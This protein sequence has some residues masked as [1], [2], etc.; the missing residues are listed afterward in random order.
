MKMSENNDHNSANSLSIAGGLILPRLKVLSIE[1]IY[2]N[3]GTDFPPIIEGLAEATFKG[4]PFSEPILVPHEH[5]AMGMAYGNY[6]VS[7]SP[8]AVILHTNVGLANATTGIINAACENVPIIVMSGRTP[9]TETGRFGSR[10][11]PI[12]WG[13]E[14][15]DQAS[16][17]REACKWEYE[18]RFPEQLMELLDRAYA[19]ANSTP[20][21]PVYLSLPREVISMKVDNQKLFSKLGFATFEST[22]DVDKIELL[23]DWLE[24]SSFPLLIT[25]R[26][27]DDES[28]FGKLNALIEKYGMATCTWWAT[29]LT[30]S[31]EN[32]CHIGSNP[33]PYLEN[34]DLILVL[35][36][37]APWQPSIHKISN[38]AKI[39]NLGPDPLFSRFPIRNFGS[40]LTI[41]GDV[42]AIITE[43]STQLE[44]R[45]KIPA[46]KVQKRKNTFNGQ[47]KKKSD[48]AKA[49]ENSI[50]FGVITKQAVSS[51]LGQILQDL[52]STV[53]SEL[54]AD[55]DLLGR[56]SHGS[57][58][59]EP[60]S[61]GLGW[62]FP[63]ALGAKIANPEKLIIAIMGDGSYLFAN[64]T[65]CHQVTEALRLPILVVVLNNRE[66]GAVKHSVLNMFP[67][68]FASRMNNV[69]LT[70]LEP[71]PDFCKVA[72]A[73]NAWSQRVDV[74]SEL[75]DVL[76]KGIEV[77]MNEQR[78]ALI[79]VLVESTQ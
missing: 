33:Q 2:V 52:D 22:P 28:S 70:S 29:G 73:S 14:M 58:F 78:A 59:Q 37:P 74:F 39:V 71:S 11:V 79:E 21:G 41:S 6:K 10:T 1:H 46:D 17:I 61:G 24:Q 36:S 47:D 49:I 43:L 72:A 51:V 4:I 75:K 60:Y 19:M 13:Q 8:Q 34:A 45:N 53:F 48:R 7:R 32:P 30:V 23:C 44:K 63:S 76:L 5:V 38:K 50:K 54:G 18:V 40:D 67:D 56:T 77:T 55:L 69:P 26:D 3:S 64:P 65:V 62:S 25:Q 66:W 9:V 16:L 35:N 31:T 42:S 68:G 57:W 15:F 20:K 27:C 12:G